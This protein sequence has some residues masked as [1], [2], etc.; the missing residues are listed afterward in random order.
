MIRK[1]DTAGG[2]TGGA[3][4]GRRARPGLPDEAEGVAATGPGQLLTEGDALSRIGQIRSIPGRLDDQ[5]DPLVIAAR[6]A[7][8]LGTIVGRCY[9]AVGARTPGRALPLDSRRRIRA[10]TQVLAGL[11][12]LSAVVTE[13]ERVS[14]GSMVREALV[15][16]AAA[17]LAIP[18]PEKTA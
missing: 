9:A 3:G 14:V 10:T 11:A 6:A 8:V 13:T 18:D 4:R 1:G 2:R 17:S 16:Q 15:L 5:A 12:E 7:E